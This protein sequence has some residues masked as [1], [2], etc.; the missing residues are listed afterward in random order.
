MV[1]AADLRFLALRSELLT[2]V[3]GLGAAAACGGGDQGGKM[4]A[5]AA[6]DGA[7]GDASQDEA[8]DAAPACTPPTGPGTTHQGNIEADETWTAETGPHLVTF[9]LYVKKG[10]L[11][12]A[13]CTEVRV[14]TG[15][16]ITVGG[17][18]EGD[19]AAK[20]VA[21]GTADKPIR[22][23]SDESGKYW[24]GLVALASGLVDLENTTLAYGGSHDTAQNFGGTLRLIGPGG[25]KPAALAH[26]V[27]VRIEHG[28]GYGLN[29]QQAGG[30]SADSSGLVISDIGR[31]KSPASDARYPIYVT[32]PSVQTLP[33][34]TYTGN[35]IDQIWVASEVAS[36]YDETFHDRGLPYRIGTG[37]SL[38]PTKSA[39]DGGLVTLTLEAGVKLMFLQ[40][41]G[42]VWSLHLGASG[43]DQPES[44]WPAKVVAMGTAEKPIVLTSAADA[45]AAGDWGG[46]AWSGG[47][48]TGNVMS[49]VTIEYAGGDLGTAG[50]GC[51]P[52]DN[53]A[54]III[55]NWRP[56]DAFI[57]DSTI[58]HSG[59]GGIVSG[60]WSDDDGPN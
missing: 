41:T 30:V 29:L 50:F 54:A 5:D 34:G 8:A 11:T 47:P 32:P 52:G 14:Q 13:P 45:P 51:G 4:P 10:T 6:A 21:H 33:P 1:H 19:P 36:D 7:S 27:D 23:T 55:T 39:A 57:T 38:A 16:T 15:Y 28:A 35:P 42:N 3:L 9:D 31:E 26:L 37:L 44:I 22:I 25:T 58:A 43:G 59:G 12:L 53:D 18:N 46:V 49:H 2:V 48:A 60:W 24:G 40:T 56:A 17:G 20:L